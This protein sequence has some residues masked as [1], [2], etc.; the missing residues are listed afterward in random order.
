MTNSKIAVHITFYVDRDINLKLIKLNKV[1]KSYLSLSKKVFIFV[2][3]NVVIKKN[4]K[5]VTFVTHNLKKKDPFKLSWL[6]RTLMEKQKNSFDYFIYSEDDI[7][8]SKSN[9]M[10]W[11]ILKDIC[12]KNDFNLAFVRTETSNKNKS[13]WSIDQPQ[14]LNKFIKISNQTF[15]LLHN[16]YCAMWIYDKFEFTKFIKS[17]FW[18]L[19]NWVGDNAFTHLKTREKSAIGW[20]GLNMSRYIASIVPIKNKRIL[21]EFCIKHLN[22]KYIEYG[23]FSIP[24][25]QLVEKKISKFKKKKFT[26]IKRTCLTLKFFYRKYMRINLKKYK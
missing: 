7:I 6:C 26:Y 4:F 23:P 14:K 10:S 8:F 19:N 25:T 3:T 17:E 12:L 11:K 21:N 13:I 20:N 2:H 15:I 24:L 5:S 1:L 22:T 9:F 16:P 18:N